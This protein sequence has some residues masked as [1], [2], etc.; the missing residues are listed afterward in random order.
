M[1][2]V[3]QLPTLRSVEQE[4]SEWIA[5]LE[6]EDV[7]PEDRV[8]FAAWL[9]ANPQHSQAF[10]DVSATWLRF[11]KAGPLAEMKTGAGARMGTAVDSD[12]EADVNA[13]V[14]ASAGSDGRTK[15]GV[16]GG[17]QAAV[18]LQHR[19]RN[20][21]LAI[22]AATVVATLLTS[23][24]LKAPHL[25]AITTA[26][27][28]QITVPLAD[29]SFMELNSNS[30]AR[31][32]YTSRQRTIHLDRGEAFFRVAH[33]TQR[34]FWVTAGG[35]WVRAVGTEFNVYL[36]PQSLQ[37]TV[38]EGTVRAGE[39]RGSLSAVQPDEQKLAAWVTLSGGQ[40]ADLD[41]TVARKR[42]LSADELAD[43]V[44]WR[45]GTVY[46]ENRPLNEV[47]AE[48]NRYSAAPLILEDSALRALPVGGAF[49]ASP[50][51]AA[52]LVRMLEQNFDVQVRQD[53]SGVH[54]HSPPQQPTP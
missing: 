2:D 32:D 9:R 28:E 7:T 48:L 42:A 38:R 12:A 23:V 4:A 34:P 53:G 15:V 35:G 44:A 39:S 30:V 24:Y 20:W 54:L 31:I 11:V 25:T 29:G 47:V 21:G 45:S 46:F 16:G 50:K 18:V 51:G 22:A 5:R 13:G 14:S 43:T 27:G 1:A 17:T 19:K 6:A 41:S 3:H 26:V 49:Q 10:E 52:A 33:D 8:R 36:R 40:Q 37:V